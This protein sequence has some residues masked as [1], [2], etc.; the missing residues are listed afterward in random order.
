MGGYIIMG[1]IMEGCIMGGCIMGAIPMG[2]IMGGCI[3][4]GPYPNWTPPCPI[5]GAAKCPLPPPT[6]GPCIPGNGP[7]PYPC[8]GKGDPPAWAYPIAGY[9]GGGAP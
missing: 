3:M 7:Y 2:Y 5:P 4:G 6:C 1:C 9:V 8:G